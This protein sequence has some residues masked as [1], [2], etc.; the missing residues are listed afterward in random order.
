MFEMD[1]QRVEPKSVP[2]KPELNLLFELV[3]GKYILFF[4]S[5]LLL[6]LSV[7]VE[8]FKFVKLKKKTQN[9]RASPRAN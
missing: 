5:L 8:F 2:S 4:S 3:K 6:L 7:A 9:A 1:R